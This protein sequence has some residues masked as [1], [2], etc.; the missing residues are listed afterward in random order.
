VKYTQEWCLILK[1]MVAAL[2]SDPS[3]IEISERRVAAGLL[4]TIHVAPKDVGRVLGR[5][6]TRLDA[7]NVIAQGWAGFEGERVKIVVDGVGAMRLRGGEEPMV[8]GEEQPRP[9]GPKPPDP[10]PETP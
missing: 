6:R 7:L 9:D 3:T 8:E 2:V 10:E 5:H 4:L 1:R